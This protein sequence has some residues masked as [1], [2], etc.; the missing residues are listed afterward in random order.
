MYIDDCVKGV[1][2]IMHCDQLIATP[3]NLG[4]SE[5]VSI[6]RLVEMVESIAGVKLDR[7]YDLTAPRGVGGRNS[8]NTFI[9]EILHWEPNTTLIAGL[10]E[11]YQWIQE[12]Y[13][14]RKKGQL[15]V[16]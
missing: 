14:K 11:T 8:D 13:Q 5:L 10:R 4:S 1:D 7:K 12:Q 6:N 15:V 9:Q 2:M 3:V 16:A